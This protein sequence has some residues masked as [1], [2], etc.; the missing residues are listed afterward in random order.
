MRRSFISAIVLLALAA[1][2]AP[3]YAR[4]ASSYVS[5]CRHIGVVGKTLFAQCR[6]KNGSFKRT[7]L[8]IAG[9]ENH[10]GALQFTSMYR[11]S[12]FQD[13]CRDIRATAIVLYATCWRDDGSFKATWIPIPGI[14]NV[15]GELRYR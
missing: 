9:V 2:A 6:R 10:D 12:T 1:A 4:P 7:S 5:S 14:A 8:P 15:D 11:A 13:N 3:A